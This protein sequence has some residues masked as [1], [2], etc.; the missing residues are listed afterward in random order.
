M[1]RLADTWPE[2]ALRKISLG[3]AEIK[4]VAEYYAQMSSS[5][6]ILTGD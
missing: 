1:K 3:D 6:K 5:V 2:L 4:D